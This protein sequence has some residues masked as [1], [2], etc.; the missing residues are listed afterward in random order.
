MHE[1]FQLP[2]QPSCLLLGHRIK[3]AKIMKYTTLLLATSLLL[4]SCKTGSITA[5]AV[6]KTIRY[7]E[8]VSLAENNPA[9]LTFAEIADSRCPE[10]A[11]C[12]WAGDA[13]VDLEIKPAATTEPQRIQMCLGDCRTL[14]PKNGFR[15]ADTT[16]V[17]VDN[18][19]YRLILTEIVPYPR[20]SGT[21]FTKEAY[22]I[23]LKIEE[24]P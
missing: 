23:K 6:E 15:E 24:A 3:H 16:M 7:H 5:Q 19:R 11:N 8:T 17:N 22:T 2:F 21:A 18:T 9:T 1:D 13:L 12:V 20:I 14:Y 10:G 4:I